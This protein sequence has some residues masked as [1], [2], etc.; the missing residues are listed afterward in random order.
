MA[1]KHLDRAPHLGIFWLVN[2]KLILDSSPLSEA[3]P[4]GDHMTHPQSHDNVWAKF[5]R[6]GRVPR[7]SEYEEYPRGRV[8][9]DKTDESFTI[10]ADN[11]LLKRKGTIAQIKR[12]LRLPN[13]VKLDTDSHY[14]CPRCL[15]GNQTNEEKD[16]A[17]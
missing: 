3:E 1:K 4:Y 9:L 8:M 14:R 2:G 11:C 5:E 7:G 10:L 16:C 6:S 12:A 15:H 17:E 13:K